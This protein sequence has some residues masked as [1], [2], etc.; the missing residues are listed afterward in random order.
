MKA[1]KVGQWFNKFDQKQKDYLIAR[2]D[3][4]SINDLRSFLTAAKKQFGD[5]VVYLP[6][7][8]VELK[9]ELYYWSS[10]RKSFHA[11]SSNNINA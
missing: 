9:G 2:A 10:D 4:F 8:N 5:A 6:A 1:I 3:K 7:L 11:L